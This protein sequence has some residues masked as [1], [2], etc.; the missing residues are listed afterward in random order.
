MQVLEMIDFFNISKKQKDDLFN[1]M[2]FKV[3]RRCLECF[4]IHKSFE[5]QI[6]TV[7]DELVAKGPSYQAGGKVLTL[8]SIPDVQEMAERFL[9]VAKLALR[10]LKEIFHLLFNH[11]FK[12]NANYEDII[13]WATKEYG[14]DDSLATQIKMDHKLWIEELIKKRNAVEHPGGN[15]GGTIH[16]K[17]YSTVIVNGTTK[18]CEPI[19]YRNEE[20]PT[21]ILFDMDS[22]V[23]NCFTFAEEIF[24]LSLYKP[25]PVSNMNIKFVEIPEGDRNPDTP[26]RFRAVIGQ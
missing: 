15:S 3:G 18:I 4:E 6:L 21:H 7:R 14:A 5:K 9:Y 20:Q 25:Q 19:W 1:I 24:V 17:N 23:H 11:N 22:Y 12:N 2:H 13:E 16:I 10:D 26:I 8:P